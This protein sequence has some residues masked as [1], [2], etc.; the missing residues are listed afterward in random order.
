MFT[1]NFNLSENLIDTATKLLK[2]SSKK[3]DEASNEEPNI[4]HLELSEEELNELS[5]GTLKSYVKKV[6]ST[7]AG[8]AKPS[9]EK[10]IETA[11]KK[12][13]NEEPNEEVMPKGMS[14]K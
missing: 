9:R 5:T 2:E 8:M 14:M 10:G 4:N 7:P 11:S 3:I 1:K 13:R 6:A 12:L